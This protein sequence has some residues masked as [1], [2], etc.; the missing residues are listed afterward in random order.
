MMQSKP[1]MMDLINEL[2]FLRR[3]IVSDDYDRALYRL[4]E[5]VPMTIHEFPS[6][7]QC[8][9]WTIPEKWTCTEAYL[10]TMDGKRIIDAADHPLHVMSYSLPFEGVVEREEL[11]KHLHVHPVWEDAI[12]FAFNIIN[13]IGDCAL[14]NDCAIHW[15]MK[16]I[17]WSFVL[18]LSREC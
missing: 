8:W 9:T 4:A 15:W 6:G 16:N 14:H 1:S 2:W 10:E 5:V 12:P 7:E 3:D 13:G 11:L 18:L 17:E